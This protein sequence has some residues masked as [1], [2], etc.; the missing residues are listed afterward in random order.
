MSTLILPCAGNSTRFPDLPPKWM[1]ENSQ[2]ESMLE[3]VIDSMPQ[4]FDQTI[5]TITSEQQEKWDAFSFINK[6]L[7]WS[8]DVNILDEPTRSAAETVYQT[9]QN[10]MVSGPIVIKDCDCAVEYDSGDLTNYIVGVKVGKDS[11]IQRLEAKS[12][13]K[14]NNDNIIEDIVEKKMVSNNICVGAYA[15][16]SESFQESYGCIHKSGVMLDDREVYV[17][18]IF[19]H[20]I[21]SNKFNSVFS[22]VEA[23]SFLDWGTLEDWEANKNL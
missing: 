3:M 21:L 13:I 4:D 20:M 9:I 15:C 23:Q 22:Y 1:L 17:S 7:K 18:H 8:V 11:G 10:C 6:K 12:F 19:S 16:G 5:V 14:K 2:G